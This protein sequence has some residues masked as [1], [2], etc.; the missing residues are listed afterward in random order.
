M[1][2]EPQPPP[3]HVSE[4]CGPLKKG[5]KNTTFELKRAKLEEF[6]RF[7]DPLSPSFLDQ[8]DYKQ[9]VVRRSRGQRSQHADNIPV[10]HE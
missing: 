5:E 2:P 10:T 1:Y 7:S 6:Q 3:A 4:P 8:Q 9:P